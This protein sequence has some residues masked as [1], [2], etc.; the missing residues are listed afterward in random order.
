MRPFCKSKLH[1]QH[2]K[3]DVLHGF[4]KVVLIM[5]PFFRPY[6]SNTY[7]DAEYCYRPSSVV[8]QSVCLLVYH[9]SESSK[10]G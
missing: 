1:T 3:F 8:C 2:N 7:V 4:G 10:N 5:G 6:H 9:R